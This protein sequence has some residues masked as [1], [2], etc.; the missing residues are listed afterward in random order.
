MKNIGKGKGG[1]CCIVYKSTTGH[2]RKREKGEKELAEKGNIEYKNMEL[3]T[4]SAIY[5][6]HAAYNLSLCERRKYS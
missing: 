5:S 2:L 6:F 3:S 1:V 4:F